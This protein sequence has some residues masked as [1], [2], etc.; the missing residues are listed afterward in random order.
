MHRRLCSKSYGA[1]RF[2]FL[3]CVPETS[4]TMKPYL[5]HRDCSRIKA[6]HFDLAQQHS[7]SRQRQLEVF[8]QLAGNSPLTKPIVTY[9]A[10]FFHLVC[11][12]R[13]PYIIG[14]SRLNRRSQ[15]NS[16]HNSHSHNTR[17]HTIIF[18]EYH[19]SQH[20]FRIHNQIDQHRGRFRIVWTWDWVPSSRMIPT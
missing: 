11:R 5:L 13:R 9:Q 1:S 4:K 18:V 3:I 6:G 14:S 2:C 17:T 12:F 20:Q 10:L 15:L 19:S 8:V 7:S 16:A